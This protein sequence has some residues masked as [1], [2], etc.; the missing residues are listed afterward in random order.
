[1]QDPAAPPAISTSEERD[2]LCPSL[3]A[4]EMRWV[5]EAQGERNNS[6]W[7]TEPGQSRRCPRWQG[8]EP[9]VRV[10]GRELKGEILGVIPAAATC[11]AWMWVQMELP[12]IPKPGFVRFLRRFQTGLLFT[13][14]APRS[15]AGISNTLVLWGSSKR[16][17]CRAQVCG[18]CGEWP[19]PG[20][21]SGT[22]GST[23]ARGGFAGGVSAL[24]P[25]PPHPRRGRSGISSHSSWMRCC[26]QKPWGVQRVNH[27]GFLP[28]PSTR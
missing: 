18:C 1:M 4:L 2:G 10:L 25:V 19:G 15:D 7:G 6:P 24:C 26:I 13:A 9:H 21:A 12:S 20:C 11:F 28:S 14:L 27:G 16:C 17:R 22:G 3:S 5:L 23:G 8:R